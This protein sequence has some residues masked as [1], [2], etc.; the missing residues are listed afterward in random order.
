MG[1][2]V[3]IWYSRQVRASFTSGPLI[4]DKTRLTLVRLKNKQ[5]TIRCME[6]ICCM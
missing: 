4:N 5:T 1:G 3:S 2:C 6:Y